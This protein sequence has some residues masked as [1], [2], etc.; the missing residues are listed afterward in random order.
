MLVGLE[1][2]S[3]AALSLGVAT[4]EGFDSCMSSSVECGLAF[5]RIILDN[6]FDHLTKLLKAE[7]LSP[8]PP[9]ELLG[10]SLVEPDKPVLI[11]F[12]KLNSEPFYQSEALTAAF[13]TLWLV[14]T[15]L[16]TAFPTTKGAYKQT[17]FVCVHFISLKVT[18]TTRANKAL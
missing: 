18:I 11:S 9:P 6:V 14:L 10:E 15:L 13:L 3:D 17:I 2:S 1:G 4:G 5:V 12:F 7:S 8:S 16:F